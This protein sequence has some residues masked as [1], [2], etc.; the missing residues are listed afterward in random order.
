[1]II[2]FIRGTEQKGAIIV[3]GEKSYIACTGAESRTYKTERGARKFME[4]KGYREVTEV[5]TDTVG[6][7]VEVVEMREVEMREVEI[8][9]V[10]D[11]LVGLTKEVS[12]ESIN[13]G[14]TVRAADPT[15]FK[16]EVTVIGTAKHF[17]SKRV[18]AVLSNGVECFA[19]GE[20]LIVV[21]PNDIPESVPV[22]SCRK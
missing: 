1:M 12:D 3:N 8:T 5:K 4:T 16:G 7:I 9:E 11:N 17:H 22:N 21:S 18:I 10:N 14:S 20:N 6:N 19:D 15:L 13:V 2:D